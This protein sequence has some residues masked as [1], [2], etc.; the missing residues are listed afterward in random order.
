[1]AHT[2]SNAIIIGTPAADFS[3]PDAFGRQHALG[4]FA[5]KRALLVAFISNRCPFVLH[6]RSH[7]AQFAKDYAT[8]GL[9]VV[10]INANDVGQRAEE[11]LERIGEEV[12]AIGY[13]F[14]YLKDEDQSMARAYGAACTPDLF[15]FDADRKLAYHGQ[16]DRSRPS[17]DIPV[18]GE[19]L[20]AAVDAVLAGETPR[21]D[22]SPSVG[23]NIKWRPG[24]EPS[25]FSSVA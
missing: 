12:A 15:L 1:M 7:L 6:I 10:A 18:T 24:N 19:D 20:R 14:P 5:D 25:W 11:S 17:N 8:R 21:A 13:E 16:Y 3:L 4:D 22:Q 9:Q 23:C 2:P